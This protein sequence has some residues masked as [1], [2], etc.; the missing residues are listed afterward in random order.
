M[1][2]V[3]GFEAG[4]ETGFMLCVFSI[5]S[6]REMKISIQLVKTLPQDEFCNRK[7]QLTVSYSRW[8]EMNVRESL[9]IIRPNA[10][11]LE[12]QPNAPFPSVATAF[13]AFLNKLVTFS[14]ETKRDSD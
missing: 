6:S 13:Y 7:H 9:W 1:A 11:T 5:Q 12:S 8:S 4:C 10:G 14:K 2:V 3:R